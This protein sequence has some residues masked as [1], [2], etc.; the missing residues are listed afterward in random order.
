MRVFAILD[1]ASSGRTT[2][3]VKIQFHMPVEHTVDGVVKVA[4]TARFFGE[5]ILPE[6]LTQA[7][8]D[9]FAA[10]CKNALADTV[11][12]GYLSDLDPAY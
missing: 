3:R 6:E 11:L 10:Y 8:R 4:Y 2:N 1:R 9:D 12:N 7:Q 5:F